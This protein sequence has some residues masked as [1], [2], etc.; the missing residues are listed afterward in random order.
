MTFILFIELLGAIACRSIDR[1][2][3]AL[4]GV[5]DAKM[6][7]DVSGN[8]VKGEKLLSHLRKLKRFRSAVLEMDS[9]TISELRSYLKPPIPV[10]GVMMATYVLLGV[11]EKEIKVS[12][13]GKKSFTNSVYIYITYIQLELVNSMMQY[14]MMQFVLKCV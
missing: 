6:D 10:H 4:K 9:K 11:D 1:L 3:K 2:E 12:Y 13:S 7:K 14:V 5:S 8:V